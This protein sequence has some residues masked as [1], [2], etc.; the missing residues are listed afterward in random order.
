[1]GKINLNEFA[2]Q[3]KYLFQAIYSGYLK[4]RPICSKRDLVSGTFYSVAFKHAKQ[5]P[6]LQLI[7]NRWIA[8]DLH[9]INVRV[10]AGSDQY[11]SDT[12]LDWLA[13]DLSDEKDALYILATRG[14]I[15][16]DS[17]ERLFNVFFKHQVL[18]IIIGDKDIARL[19]KWVMSGNIHAC[20]VF[21]FMLTYRI[22]S[23]KEQKTIWW[24]VIDEHKKDFIEKTLDRMGDFRGC[25]LRTIIK[26]L[27]FLIVYEEEMRNITKTCKRIGITRKTFYNWYMQDPAFRGVVGNHWD[28]GHHK[29][30]S[31]QNSLWFQEKQKERILKKILDEV[32]SEEIT[33][34]SP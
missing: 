10:K 22:V 31:Y 15:S 5:F 11:I 8:D 33:H 13:T 21:L 23:Y 12:D 9:T 6:L 18:A 1:M 29:N 27:E 20:I 25:Q 32:N 14:Q 28:V 19:W 4:K 16:E 7:K 30:R 17:I 24:S 26:K 2:T 34:E 3:T